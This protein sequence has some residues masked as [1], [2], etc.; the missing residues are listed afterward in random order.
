MQPL[1]LH[2]RH[3][4]PKAKKVE[5]KGKDVSDKVVIPKAKV[6]T[7]SSFWF[8]MVIICSVLLHSCVYCGDFNR[9]SSQISSVDPDKMITCPFIFGRIDA[10]T[11]SLALWQIGPW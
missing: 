6:L 10:L 11:K 8:P 3:Q 2:L 4:R 7:I 1:Q 9:K 5:L